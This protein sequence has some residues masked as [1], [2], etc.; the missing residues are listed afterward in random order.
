MHFISHAKALKYRR[1]MIIKGTIY[2]ED[3]FN[4]PKVSVPP[5][6]PIHPSIAIIAKLAVTATILFACLLASSASAQTGT[7]A[8]PTPT[9]PSYSIIW[10]M[11][12]TPQVDHYVVFEQTPAKTWAIVPGSEWVLPSMIPVKFDNVPEGLHVYTV[13]ANVQDLLQS[14]FATPLYAQVIKILPPGLLKI[15]P[16][17]LTALNDKLRV[18][19]K[20]FVQFKQ[21]I[22]PDYPQRILN[23]RQLLE[24]SMAQKDATQPQ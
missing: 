6:P 17:K 3:T 1:S 10:D 7:Q 2:S 11:S 9:G 20:H 13:T 19:K 8:N 12:P 18:Q 14:D 24:L 23:S 22:A 5:P 21:G 15:Q 16:K 4:P